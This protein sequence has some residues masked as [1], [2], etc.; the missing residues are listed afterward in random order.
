MLPAG[1]LCCFVAFLG[2]EVRGDVD[3]ATRALRRGGPQRK[4]SPSRFICYRGI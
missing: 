4:L 1:A 2:A 3:A